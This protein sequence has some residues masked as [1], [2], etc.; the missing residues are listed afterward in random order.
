M[1]DL[2]AFSNETF[3][4][5]AWINAALKEA[6]ADESLEAYIS[7]LSTKLHIMS[8]DYTDQLETAMVESMST[9]PRILSE[10]TRTEDQL[11]SVDAEMKGLSHHLNSFD[12][13]NVAGVEDLSRLDT[14]KSNMEKCKATL[15]EHARWSQ[16]VREAK[17]IMEGGGKLSDSADRIETMYRSLAILKNLPG[18]LEREETCETFKNSLLSALRPIV[19]R[20]VAGADIAPLQEYLYVFK[21]LGRYVITSRPHFT[22]HVFI[23]VTKPFVRLRRESELQEEYVRARPDRIKALWDEYSA[24][25]HQD[26]AKWLAAFL[27]KIARLLGEEEESATTLFGTGHAAVVLCDL[28]TESLRPLTSGLAGRLAQLSSAE[29]VFDAY[30]VME[31]FSRR[32]VA[33]LQRVDEARQTAAVEVMFSGFASF[34]P[35]YTEAEVASLRAQ[36]VDLLDTVVFASKESGASAGQSKASSKGKDAGGASLDDELFGGEGDAADAY[37]TYGERLLAAADQFQAPVER[38]LQRAVRYAGGLSA[39]QTVRSAAG[40]FVLFLKHLVSKIDDL[41]VASG[42]PRDYSLS[43][44]GGGLFNASTADDNTGSAAAVAQQKL[45][46]QQSAADRLAQQLELSEVDSRVL[47]T[48]ALRALQAVGRGTKHF[49]ALED[50]AGTVLS[51]LQQNLFTGQRAPFSLGPMLAQTAQSGVTLGSL[52][53]LHTLHGDLNSMSELRSFLAASTSTTPAQAIFAAATVALKKLRTA[54]SLLLFD[55]CLEAPEKMINSYA[56]EDVWSQAS[57]TGAD[58]AQLRENMLPQSVVTQVN[59]PQYVVADCRPY[60]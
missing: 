39:K 22:S 11:R 2:T 23:S 17:I 24:V 55:L 12:Q 40:T 57:D 37:G 20:D 14:L 38:S 47:I 5:P 16:L 43:L 58:L 34:M 27:G 29:A 35:A 56:L 26:F 30:C 44:S 10:I 53:A 52:Y 18:N 41:R 3:S 60:I 59:P 25:K 46:A 6:P 42:F 45:Q 54:A 36:F 19:R 21:K 50:A 9:M 31:E 48:S 28:L 51:T 1:A 7:S 33:Y 13:R 32:V 49:R 15:E 8:Q 4:A